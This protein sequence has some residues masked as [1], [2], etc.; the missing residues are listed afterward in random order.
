MSEDT[1]QVAEG[2]EAVALFAGDE[3]W[4]EAQPTVAPSAAEA[5]TDE[6]PIAKAGGVR[7]PEDGLE[8]PEVLPSLSERGIILQAQGLYHIYE[9]K[10]RDGN[11]VA[12]RGLHVTIHE[13]EAV[14]VVGPSGSGKSTLLKSLGGL[15]IPTAGM[16]SLSG[17]PLHRLSGKRLVDVRRSTVSFIFQEGNLLPHMSALD[18]VRQPLRHQA[19]PAKETRQRATELLTRL[20]MEERMHALPEKLSGG[21]A[22]RVAIARAL[23]TRPRL[24]LA[25]EPTGALDPITSRDVLG[26]FAELHHD[27]DV[28]FLIVTHSEEVASFADRI[29]ELR[30][31]RFIAQHGTDV[32]FDSL[33]GSRELLIDEVGML[34]LPP[35]LLTELGGPGRWSVTHQ[36]AGR[37]H[38]ESIDHPPGAEA[39]DRLFTGDL[40]TAYVQVCPAC[41]HDYGDELNA[42]D[43]PSC[44]SSR[45]RATA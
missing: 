1:D 6:A 34:A 43:C 25:D 21:E 18:N 36:E 44:G 17:E 3:D 27:E 12:L 38:L 40:S 16:V 26:L 13:A 19:L 39:A 20:G 2:Q 28:A 31:G 32:H 5:A 15:M 42:K 45:P 29:L 14:A 22:Q 30:D 8:A 4:Q 24:I 35:D 41:Q 10:A 7:P 23:I 11:V 37:F 9:S 33:G